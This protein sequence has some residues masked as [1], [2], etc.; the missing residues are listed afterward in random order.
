MIDRIERF[1]TL[2]CKNI[3]DDVS[4]AEES[5]YAALV[6]EK[7][8]AMYGESW[9]E[10]HTMAHIDC[11]LEYFDRC[12][13]VASDPDAIEMAIWF[14]DC[15][16]EVGAQDNE[17]RSRDWFL[18][19][20]NRHLDSDFRN[21]VDILIMDTVHRT[22]PETSDGKLLADIDLTSFGLPWEHYMR[23]GDNVRREMALDTDPDKGGNKFAFLDALLTRP[24][25][26]FSP[27]YKE[28]FEAGARKNLMRHKALLESGN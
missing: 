28:H 22:E 12:Q 27:Y 13:H 14:H 15:I 25:I 10:Y 4:V 16:Y 5:D 18:D 2:W 9:R 6:Y 1:C 23:D 26:Y 3:A 20:S 19:V 24:S 17:A 7:L 11:C 8:A 21:V